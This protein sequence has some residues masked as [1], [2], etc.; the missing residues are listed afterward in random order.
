MNNKIKMKRTSIIAFAAGVT[1]TAALA[2]LIAAGPDHGHDHGDHEMGTAVHQP[3]AEAAPEFDMMAEMAKLAT[4]GANHQALGIMVGEWAATTSFSMGPDAPAAEGT[5][6]MTVQWVLG[7][8]Y[9][10]SSF[11]SDFMGQPFEGIGYIGYDIAHEQYVSSWMDTMSTKIT[12]MTGGEEAG[13]ALVLHGT[14]TTPRGDNPMKIVTK[15]TDTNT[16]VDT[17]FDKTP[18]GEWTQSGT[19]VYTR[20]ED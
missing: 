17:F 20:I 5:G 11:K 2:L 1:S 6:T 8:R 16:W 18:E 19:I 4:P 12:H 3:D 15:F 14:S 7:K 9:I 13:D 10:Q